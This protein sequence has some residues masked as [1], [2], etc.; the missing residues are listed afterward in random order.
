MKYSLLIVYTSLFL[1]ACNTNKTTDQSTVTATS[2]QP[3]EAAVALQPELPPYVKYKNWGIGSPEKIQLIMD[4]YAAWDGSRPGEMANYFADTTIYDLPDGL[5]LTTTNKTV[6]QTFRKWRSH[7][8]T[9]SN[10]PYSI[11]SLHNKDLNQD[12]VIAWTWNKWHER[13]GKKDSM[14]FCDNWLIKENR[15]V[16]LNS[17]EQRASK[18]L[19][20][21]LNQDIQQ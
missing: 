8:G 12:W 4:V 17:L 1:V 20:K 9:T 18:Q 11:V 7:Y 5:R 2:S 16:Y 14:L 10:Q 15:I 6:H 21:I 19:I 13:T 3:A